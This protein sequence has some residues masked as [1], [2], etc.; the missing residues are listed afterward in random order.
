MAGK[1]LKPLWTI[2]A[3]EKFLQMVNLGTEA[4]LSLVLE[5]PQWLR[6]IC[7]Q[8]CVPHTTGMLTAWKV[9]HSRLDNF[10]VHLLV[11]TSFAVAFLRP[12]F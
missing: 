3:S 8:P 1:S 12:G 2:L 10:F 7:S 4:A 11:L 6:V 9:L 5:V